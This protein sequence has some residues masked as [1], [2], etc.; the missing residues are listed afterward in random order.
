MVL[1]C[2]FRDTYRSGLFSEVSD[3]FQPL[4]KRKIS[5]FFFICS[6]F[7]SNSNGCQT[8]ELKMSDCG[9]AE[10]QH[11]NHS[12]NIFFLGEQALLDQSHP[13]A[14]V[15]FLTF[16]PRFNVPTEIYFASN[17]ICRLI[18]ILLLEKCV[19]NFNC[20]VDVGR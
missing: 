12:A 5:S 13:N 18:L 4:V 6:N 10:C 19:Y 2:Y 17:L 3:T 15:I 8:T 20:F 11:K 1:T 7:Y 14:C 9:L 16:A